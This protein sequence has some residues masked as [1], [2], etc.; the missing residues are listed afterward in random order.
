M[1]FDEQL[2]Y[3]DK[4]EAL[5]AKKAHSL[6]Q[7]MPQD[8]YRSDTI[9]DLIASLSKAQG[10]FGRISFNRKDAYFNEDYADFNAIMSTVRPVLSENKL[11]VVQQQRIHDGGLTMLHSILLHESG[12]WIESRS[13]ILPIKDGVTAY[14]SE[15]NLQKSLALQS[16]LGLS[17]TN[18]PADDH[19]YMAMRSV[20]DKGEVGT[21]INHMHENLSRDTITKEQLEEL[22]YEL[23]EYPDIAKMILDQWKLQA[24]ADMPKAKYMVAINKIRSIKLLRSGVK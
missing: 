16:L 20:R 24:L 14:E 10:A 2:A 23:A 13:R 6:A 18:N 9:N 17:I 4:L 11:A 7:S 15:L 5:I 21:S 8:H 1:N 3:L 12:Q 19:G 22:E